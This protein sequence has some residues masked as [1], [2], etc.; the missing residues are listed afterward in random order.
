MWNLIRSPLI[1]TLF[2]A[3]TSISA[4]A[5]DMV[6][7]VVNS[8]IF[9]NGTVR[10]IRSGLNIY[11]QRR[12]A[13][14]LNFL[15]PKV[16]GYGIPPGGR[17]EVEMISGFQRDPKIPLGQPSILLVAGTPQQ[18]LPGRTVGYTVSEGENPNTF[19]ITPKTPGGLE[20]PNIVSNAPGAARDPIRQ[21]GIKIVHVGMTMAFVNRGEKGR[22]EVRI[23]DRNGKI[24]KRGAGEVEFLPTP[25]PQIFPTNI[26]HGKRNHN[27]QRLRPGEVLGR[28]QGTLPLAFLLFDKNQGFGNKGLDG[29]GVLSRRE[30]DVLNYKLPSSL[31]RYTGGLIVQDKNGD[32]L[33]EPN[34]DRIIGGIIEAAPEGAKG[35]EARTPLHTAGHYLSRPTADFNPKAGTKLGGS[36]LLVE[37]VG[38]DKKGVYEPT[39]ALLS[40]PDDI[41]SPDGSTYT[42]SVVVE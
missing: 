39:F 25:R 3:A 27:W 13:M 22:V 21:Y 42:Y 32:G 11:L 26:P 29:V 23:F 16:P 38:G 12:D 35:H 4:Q 14:G 18:A 34:G 41:T 8:P 1:F 24:V 28:T 36:I 30:L 5:D 33:I 10:D 17:M 19:V 37:Y 7:K 15:D 40:D 31:R 9:A 6:N 20:V 2:G